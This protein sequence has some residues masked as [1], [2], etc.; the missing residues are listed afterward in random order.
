M[1][2]FLDTDLLE[3]YTEYIPIFNLWADAE[4]KLVDPLH[5]MANAFDKNS[6]SL[7]MLVIILHKLIIVV[8]AVEALPLLQSYSSKIN[9][10]LQG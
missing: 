6:S 9:Q 3:V 5:A 8:S 4:S 1:S 10:T 7:K 2:Y